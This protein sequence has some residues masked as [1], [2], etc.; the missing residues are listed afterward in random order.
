MRSKQ[1]PNHLAGKSRRSSRAESRAEA[2]HKFPHKFTRKF[3]PAACTPLPCQEY[4][5][6]N[7]TR[8][9]FQR[10][11]LNGNNTAG[12]HIQTPSCTIQTWTSSHSC[13]FD[14]LCEGTYQ[15]QKLT[16]V[17]LQQSQGICRI[18]QYRAFLDAGGNQCPV[19]PFLTFPSVSL[20]ETNLLV[21]P[22]LTRNQGIT[23]IATC[24]S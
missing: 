17:L 21:A 13:K 7:K 20:K 10:F 16:V 23:Q 3:R 15:I 14:Q 8:R 5:H 19:L 22:L 11:S 9:V 12:N 4:I 2:A 18:I 6:G 24:T 1:R